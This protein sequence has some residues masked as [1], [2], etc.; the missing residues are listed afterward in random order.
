MLIRHSK[1]SANTLLQTAFSAILPTRKH[2]FPHPKVNVV[3]LGLAFTAN[4]N[5]MIRG[6]FKLVSIVFWLIVGLVCFFYFLKPQKKVLWSAFFIKLI[7]RNIM[8]VF[9]INP[10]FASYWTPL[11]LGEHNK[12]IQAENVCK[13]GASSLT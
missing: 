4:D 11:F 7:L 2:P 9:C 6:I 1:Y 5:N 3:D 8:R 13:I 12:N 10:F